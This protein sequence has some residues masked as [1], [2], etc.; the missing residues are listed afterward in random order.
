MMSDYASRWAEC[1]R[2]LSA[3]GVKPEHYAF[4]DARVMQEVIADEQAGIWTPDAAEADAPATAAPVC[5]PAHESRA[6]MWTRAVSEANRETF[7]LGDPAPVNP[8]GDAVPAGSAA[9]SRAAWGAAVAAANADLIRR[10]GRV[11]D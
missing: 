1:R 8:K 4:H 9:R 5:A 2:R 3:A 10:G 7:A 6:S 11:G